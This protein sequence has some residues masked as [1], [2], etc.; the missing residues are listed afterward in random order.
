MVFKRACRDAKIKDFSPPD[1]KHDFAC[2]L[3]QRGN[4]LYIVRNLLDHK[5]GRMTQRYAHLR[6]E[7]LRSAVES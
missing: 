2:N 4:D 7:K 6:V 3:V 5:D 1:L